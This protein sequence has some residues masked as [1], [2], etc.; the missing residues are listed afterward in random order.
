MKT[1]LILFIASI[2]SV[3]AYGIIKVSQSHKQTYNA[4]ITHVEEY[5]GNKIDTIRPNPND[6]TTYRYV[7]RSIEWKTFL[8]MADTFQIPSTVQ[9]FRYLTDDDVFKIREQFWYMSGANNIEDLAIAAFFAEMYYA[10]P[11]SIRY[12]QQRLKADGFSNLKVT[13]KLNE[14]TIKAI[15]SQP[16]KQMWDWLLKQRKNYIYNKTASQAMRIYR[17]GLIIRANDFHQKFETSLGNDKPTNEI[18]TYE[19]TKT[20]IEEITKNDSAQNN[21]DDNVTIIVSSVP[22]QTPRSG[23]TTKRK[24]NTAS[25]IK[26]DEIKT[27]S[28]TKENGV[29][30]VVSSEND[31]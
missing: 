25:V 15:E 1:L 23:D 29:R 20:P 31:K 19:N 7:N 9:R 13:G 12:F 11:A 17:K 27:M 3:A 21:L 24:E 5:E 30:I 14:Q 2:S 26:N 16:K 6:I 8:A 10:A 28:D 18:E 22:L 4:W